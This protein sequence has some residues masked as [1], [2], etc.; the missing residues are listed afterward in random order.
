MDLLDRLHAAS[1]RPPITDR[2]LAGRKARRVLPGLVNR[3]WKQ[4]SR[5]VRKGGRHPADEQLHQ[6]RKRSKQLR[7]A[8]ELATPVMGKAAKRTAKASESLQTVLGEHHD[9]VVASDWLARAGHPGDVERAREVV[10]L[11][12]VEDDR[13]RR[14]DR[15]W[16]PLYK[17][18]AKPSRRAWMK[19]GG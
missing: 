18:L 9:A 8:S 14:L 6:L 15:K 13:R 10:S 3:R 5:D 4:L 16:R 12:K 17:K 11:I 1:A 19:T 2:P 7:Y